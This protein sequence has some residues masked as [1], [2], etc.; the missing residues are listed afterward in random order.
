MDR[1]PHGA[2]HDYIGHG[3]DYNDGKLWFD[4]PIT[5][6]KS[7]D[8]LMGW[9]PTAG[10]DPIFW[11]HHSNIDRIWQKW[12]NS[13]NGQMITLELLKSVE[14]S[15][16]F[17][18]EN[19]KKV[20]YTPEQVYNIL[21]SMDYDYDDTKVQSKSKSNLVK[22][23]PQHVLT[24]ST[25][26]K[27]LTGKNT[28]VNLSK[29]SKTKSKNVIIEVEASYQNVPSG[30][31][32]VYVNTKKRNTKS[33]NFVGFMS[34]FGEDHAMPGK[35]CK[36][37]CCKPVTADGRT[38]IVFT[39]QHTNSQSWNFHFY[40]HNGHSTGDLRIDKIRIKSN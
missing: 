30:I 16:V 15:Y 28:V 34:F 27:L 32:E 26:K 21:Y 9:V 37:G 35:S 38:K 18:D 22:S 39:F 17:F 4:N 8:G 25:P 20:K 29:V 5:G 33:K 23:K 19:G 7:H 11:T 14:W 36:S 13:D 10:F 6:K 24:Q 12:T 1:A 40:N 31:Y 3:N 2:I